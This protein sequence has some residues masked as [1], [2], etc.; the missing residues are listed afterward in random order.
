MNQAR[1]TAAPSQNISSSV[2]S[3]GGPAFG[4]SNSSSGAG[5]APAGS[6]IQRQHSSSS[7]G[8]GGASGRNFIEENKAVAAAARH[9]AKAEAKKDDGLVYMSKREYGRVRGRVCGC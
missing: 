1:R 3:P 2:Y 5:R 4:R 8:S 7:G 9:A 6:G